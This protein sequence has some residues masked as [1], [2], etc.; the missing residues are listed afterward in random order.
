MEIKNSLKNVGLS[1]QEASIYVAL[2]KM[3]NL[4]ASRI[5]K[6]IGVKRTTVYPILQN[7]VSKGFV[8]TIQKKNQ[9][10]YGAAKPQSIVAYLEKK[11]EDFES[12]IPSLQTLEKSQAQTLIP[13]K[14]W[15]DFILILSMNTETGLM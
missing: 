3:G 5:A 10:Y 7:M 13:K 8:Q 6:T 4:A 1:E 2:L 9:K 12:I 14:S 11:L 15:K